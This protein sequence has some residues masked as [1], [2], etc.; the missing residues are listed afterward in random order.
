MPQQENDE[1]I[2]IKNVFVKEQD[3]I[4][5]AIKSINDGSK[6]IALVT[7]IEDRLLKIVTDGDIRRAIIRGISIEEPIENIINKNFIFVNENYCEEDIKN[8]FVEKSI[9]Q[10][11]VLNKEMKIID[12]IYYR[13]F[14][15]KIL[16]NL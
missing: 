6:G 9:L 8:I 16:M 12:I 11:P 7:D 10:I 2:V 14:M 15:K 3:T 13:D 5:Q 1:E 4:K